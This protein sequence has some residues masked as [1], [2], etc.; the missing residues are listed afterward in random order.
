[1]TDPTITAT[2]RKLARDVQSVS[3][4]LVGAVNEGCDLAAALL[5]VKERLEALADECVSASE[6]VLLREQGRG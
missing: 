4:S 3:Y 2:V 5:S 6:E 1:M